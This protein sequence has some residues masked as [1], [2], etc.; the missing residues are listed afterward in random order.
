MQLKTQLDAA[1]KHLQAVPAQPELAALR[2]EA[3]GHLETKQKAD[4]RL[5]DAWMLMQPD[6]N[7]AKQHVPGTA[8]QRRRRAECCAGCSPQGS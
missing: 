1:Q 8:Q 5:R 7:E 6:N 3:G 2:Q 4:D